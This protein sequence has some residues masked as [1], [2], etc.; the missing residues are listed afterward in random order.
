MR[1]RHGGAVT[2][3]TVAVA[4][5]LALLAVAAARER[6]REGVAGDVALAAQAADPEPIVVEMLTDRA[7]FP[8]DVA[9]TLAVALQGSSRLDLEVPEP[10]RTAVARIT[11]QPGA[12]FPW[13]THPG[14]ILVNVA[15]GEL[16]YVPASDCSEHPY[17]AGTA[18]W[19]GGPRGS[20]LG[21][22][23]PR[24]SQAASPP[25]CVARRPPGAAP[26]SPGRR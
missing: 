15:E 1:R 16:V 8:D 26:W 12:T 19:E 7:E 24:L 3:S 22:G 21:R 5:C 4:A 2:A 9:M 23:R 6:A 17:A 11:V 20:P 14:P 10:S 18:F 25:E 13:H